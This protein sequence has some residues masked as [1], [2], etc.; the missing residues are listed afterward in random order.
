MKPKILITNDDGILSE[1]IYALWESMEEVGE[2]Y[3]AAPNSG[4]SGS[5]HSLTLSEP[6]RVKTLE[7]KNGFK[8]WSINGTPV[9]CVKIAIKILMGGKPDIII[10]GINHGANLGNNIIYSGTVSAAAEGTLSGIPSMAISLAS[11]KK[12]NYKSAK[13]YAKKIIKHIL[14]YG[15]PVGTLLNV[16]IPNC[17]YEQING[18]QITRQGNQCFID[19]F[20]MRVDP[21]S[22]KYYWIKGKMIDEDRSIDFDGNAIKENYVSITPIYYRLTNETYLNDLKKYFPDELS[23]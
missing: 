12:N 13:I 1:G 18:I 2:T 23:S 19:E 16:N 17:D 20:E 9:D 3:I 8:G 21:R 15:L 10:S 5:S 6:L 11:D 7:R 22:S 4:K 14:K